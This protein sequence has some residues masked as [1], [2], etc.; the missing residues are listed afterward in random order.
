MKKFKMN[1]DLSKEIFESCKG[2]VKLKGCYSN[3]AQ[4]TLKHIIR[5]EEF[6]KIQIVFGAW[7]SP[8]SDNNNKVYARHCFF[9]LDDEVIDP[10]YFTTTR[11]DKD[12]NYLVFKT[13]N[14]EDYLHALGECRGDTYLEK[15]TE[16]MF[17]HQVMSLMKENIFLIG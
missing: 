3:V 12:L 14:L 1:Y 13:F 16:N 2:L 9:L 8:I 17:R 7:E 5:K 15:Y 6:S 4:I 10:T 11:D